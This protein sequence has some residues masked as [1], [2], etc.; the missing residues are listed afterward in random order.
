MPSIWDH[1]FVGG[2][3]V[4]TLASTTP[5][6]ARTSAEKSRQKRVIAPASG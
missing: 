3:A 4:V 6:R 5:G 1:P 2:K